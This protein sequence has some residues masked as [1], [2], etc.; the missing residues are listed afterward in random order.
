MK[1][2]SWIPALPVRK[3]RAAL[4][5]LILIL[6][7]VGIGS[8]YLDVQHMIA[9]RYSAS[10]DTGQWTLAQTDVEFLT[11][12]DAITDA[13]MG[14]QTLNDVR[15]RYDVFYSRVMTLKAGKIFVLLHEDPG[16][17]SNFQQILG[18]LNAVQ[19]MIDGP[20]DA[21]RQGLGGLEESSHDLRQNVR[22]VALEGLRAFAVISDAERKKV[23]DALIAAGILTMALIIVLLSM[24]A[25]L[26]GLDSKNRRMTTEKLET[27]DRLKAIIATALDA[28]IVVTARGQ[29]V[30]F[31]GSAAEV[32]GVARQAA[33]G[34]DMADLILP[35]SE[36]TVYP[37]VKSLYQAAE[38]RRLA[39]QGRLRLTAHHATG[40]DFP[41]EG[42]ITRVTSTGQDLYVAFLRDLSTVVASEEA[43]MKA[44]DDALAGERAK[45]KL[46]AVMSHEMRTPLNGMIGMIELLDDTQ[47]NARQRDYLGVMQISGRLLMHHVEDVLNI[48]Q[49][50]TGHMPNQNEWFDLAGLIE[51]VFANQR[52]A[53]IAQGNT[54]ALD[55]PA[56]GLTMMQSDPFQLRQ[57]LMN[58]V[59]NAIKFTRNGDIRL[60][61]D[62]DAATASTV[63]RVSDSGIGIDPADQD[64]VFEDFV[65]LDTTYSRRVGGTGLGLG[66]TRRIVQNMGGEIWVDSVLGKGSSFYL[67]IPGVLAG[68]QS[69]AEPD[70]PPPT[71]APN[72]PLHVL[73]VEDNA[74]NQL[75]VREMLTRLGHS[76]EVAH[77][78]A[79][80]VHLAAMRRFDLILMD[81]SMPQM[82]GV[83]ATFAI[84]GGGGLSCQ[85]PIIALT[86]HALSVEV[87]RFRAAGMQDVLI[88]PMTGRAL[89]AVL[90]RMGGGPVDARLLAEVMAGM[91]PARGPRLLAAFLQDTDAGLSRVAVLLDRRA[92]PAEIRHEIHKLCGSTALFGARLVSD[93]LRRS[94]DLCQTGSSADL[95]RAL[96]EIGKLWSESREVIRAATPV[97]H[98]ASAAT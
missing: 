89:A 61:F 76:I 20:D 65:I 10:S 98:M 42:S 46:L 38:V 35:A 75:V 2:G 21:L 11:F 30:E 73:V 28:V 15:K 1:I 33:L 23:A 72:A 67:R 45:A 3:L 86:A 49:L 83:Q 93:A 7:L 47:M 14:R 31:N 43:L 56:S 63:L 4:I 44:R 78:G 12:R 52:P 19:P 60:A 48:A 58:L 36:Q 82:D 64:R 16:F 18:W 37:D 57:V 8:L 71:N 74:I 81:I 50:E 32:F 77:D 59:G 22:N 85:T 24:V 92:D 39:G 70:L 66:I 25:I 9:T 62:P 87:E 95:D 68:P 51:E 90:A 13:E 53:A 5:G 96:T 34:Q 41:I 54:L 55:L 69:R 97:L 91:G 84:R 79:Q 6:S 94:E 29:I 27:L 88:K 80:A 17:A 26:L 40:R